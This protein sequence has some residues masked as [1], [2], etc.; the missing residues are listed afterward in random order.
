MCQKYKEK[1]VKNSM[2]G[3]DRATLSFIGNKNPGS[4]DKVIAIATEADFK[5]N[6]TPENREYKFKFGTQKCVAHI[7]RET[8]A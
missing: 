6:E 7:G 3:L 8:E 1:A 2:R 5:N 4:L